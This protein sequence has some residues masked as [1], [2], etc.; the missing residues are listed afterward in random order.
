METTR[1]EYDMKK[2]RLYYVDWLKVFV[3][4]A[5]I[6]Y[7]AAL[8]YTRLGDIYIKKAITDFKV[9]PFILVTMFYLE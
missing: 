9:I 3:I 8:T 5:L 6:P 2:K 7:H 1:R 4:A